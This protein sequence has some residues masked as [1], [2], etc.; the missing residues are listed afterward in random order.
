MIR[1]KKM[2]LVHRFGEKT[3]NW[4][5]KM[6][7]CKSVS[8]SNHMQAVCNWKLV[9]CN[10]QAMQAAGIPAK[11]FI[12]A[13]SYIKGADFKNTTSLLQQ[14]MQAAGIPAEIFIFASHHN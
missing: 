12:V 5:T 11:Y 10:K 6:I 13:T 2:S 1:V 14:A 7:Y 4:M 8:L 3:Q 9:C